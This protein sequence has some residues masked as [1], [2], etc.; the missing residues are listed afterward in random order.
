MSWIIGIFITLASYIDQ[1]LKFYLEIL[2]CLFN[3]FHGLSL[4]ISQFLAQ[5]YSKPGAYSSNSFTKTFLTQNLKKTNTSGTN[6]TS[7]SDYDSF[8]KEDSK[9][10][11]QSVQK[12]NSKNKT[13]FLSGILL[14]LS[15]LNKCC[16]KKR[17]R[18]AASNFLPKKSNVS[19]GSVKSQRPHFLEFTLANYEMD[20][21]SNNPNFQTFQTN[22]PNFE[23]NLINSNSNGKKE[24]QTSDFGTIY[25]N[26]ENLYLKNENSCISNEMEQAAS[27]NN[28]I[29]FYGPFTSSV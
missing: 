1:N 3:S 24:I 4:L 17:K 21:D 20:S 22:L 19:R 23:I 28:Y 25:A 10:K 6:N 16:I 15:A 11:K 14:Y 18:N 5:K 8:L 13:F 27:D 12:A 29:Q 9:T 2:F 7:S 26:Q